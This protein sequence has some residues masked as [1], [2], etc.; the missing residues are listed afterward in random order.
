MTTIATITSKRQLTVPKALLDKLGI[1][2]NSKVALE[3]VDEG[4]L[5]KPAEK[6]L[7]GLAGSVKV[8]EKLRGVPAKTAI[9]EAKKKRFKG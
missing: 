8:S 6:L 9:T 7:D 4:L 1:K 2:S 5:L 3:E